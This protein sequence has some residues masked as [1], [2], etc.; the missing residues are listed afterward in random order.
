MCYV[1]LLFADIFISVNGEKSMRPLEEYFIFT[2][3]S[4]DQIRVMQPQGIR[5]A[6]CADHFDIIHRNIESTLNVSQVCNNTC[7]HG[8]KKTLVYNYLNIINY[9]VL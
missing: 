5:S 2:K 4:E 6:Q 9:L 7:M 1:K 8:K 3:R